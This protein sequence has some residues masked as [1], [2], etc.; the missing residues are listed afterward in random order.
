MQSY[1]LLNDYYHEPNK[2]KKCNIVVWRWLVFH[3][4]NV[5][6]HRLGCPNDLFYYLLFRRDSLVAVKIP[7]L[8][9]YSK[10]HCKI[11][12]NYSIH[13]SRIFLFFISLVA[14]KRAVL[15]NACQD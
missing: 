10:F 9:D 11:S 6:H 8:T 4:F 1:Y 14:L 2:R 7:I 15:L 12:Y 13:T 3:F 5:R